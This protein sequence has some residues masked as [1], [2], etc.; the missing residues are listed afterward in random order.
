MPSSG[1]PARH[2]M[3]LSTATVRGA[4]KA[5]GAALLVLGA[6]PASALYKVVQPDGSVT[7]TDRPPATGNAR[8][9]PLGRNLE[10]VAAEPA[11][12][13]ELRQ[14][15]QRYPV[16]LYTA[17]DCTPCDSG[18]N[19]L[20]SRGVPYTERRVETD[21]DTLALE[22]LVGGR[23]VPA[24][25][26]GTQALRGLSE[27]DWSSYLDAA[28]YPRESR[29]PRGWQPPAATPL[30]ERVTPT[31]RPAAAAPAPAPAA[32][33]PAAPEPAAGTVRF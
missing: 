29:L 3:K 12:P 16:T 1:P 32:A 4:A 28:G 9:T 21:E 15:A 25:T 24:L 27:T 13:L 30:V 5:L 17:P 19:L 18:R 6:L 26:I 33:P 14:A 2:T 22:R 31:A 23:T 10:P 7:Y 8:V 11:M 20:R